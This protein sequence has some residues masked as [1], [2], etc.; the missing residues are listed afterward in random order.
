[1][2]TGVLRKKKIFYGVYIDKQGTT[3]VF[4]YDKAGK[5][6]TFDVLK[7]LRVE[8]S[9]IKITVIW[10]GAP[11]HRAKVNKVNLEPKGLLALPPAVF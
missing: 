8:F 2:K 5:T 7:K 11:Y 1:M 4:V 3:R 10:D 6:N 9:D